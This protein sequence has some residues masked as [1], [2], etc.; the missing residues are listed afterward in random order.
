M[1]SVVLVTMNSSKVACQR[2]SMTLVHGCSWTGCSSTR[3]KRKYCGL[4]R[5]VSSSIFQTNCWWWVWTLFH[6][7]VHDQSMILVSTLISDLSMRMHVTWMCPVFSRFCNRS[8]ASVGRSV[9]WSY[10]HFSRHWCC[11]SCFSVTLAGLPT[12]LLDRLQ[13]ALHAAVRLLYGLWKYNHVTPLLHNLHWLRVRDSA[14]AASQDET[15]YLVIDSWWPSV[16]WIFYVLFY[17]VILLTFSSLYIF[18]FGWQLFMFIVQ[19]PCSTLEVHTAIYK[20]SFIILIIHA[21]RGLVF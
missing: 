12:R 15:V 11:H 21:A 10:S 1:V 4:R 18:A 9:V 16:T 2:A 13:S 3:R 20:L 19:R 5:F 7:S 8:V 14:S 6:Q 17:V